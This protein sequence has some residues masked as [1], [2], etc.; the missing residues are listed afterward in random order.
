LNKKTP[1]KAIKIGITKNINDS[2]SAPEST[3]I[4]KKNAKKPNHKD[5]NSFLKK[6]DEPDIF[7][8][9]FPSTIGIT[10]TYLSCLVNFF[11]NRR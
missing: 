3:D 1:N 7:S 11:V 10:G 2:D 5:G 6:N 4:I 9:I 8:I